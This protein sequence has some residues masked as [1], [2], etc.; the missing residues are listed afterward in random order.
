M[1][2]KRKRGR[3]RHTK[4]SGKMQAI[5]AYRLGYSF[6]SPNKVTL[7]ET[8][9]QFGVSKQYISQE[10]RKWTIDENREFVRRSAETPTVAENS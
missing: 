10:E 6:G 3:P 7:R 5:L 1:E 8:A 4:P 2:N 9:E